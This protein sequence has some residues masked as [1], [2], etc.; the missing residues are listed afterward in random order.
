MSSPLF[1]EVQAKHRQEQLLAEATRERLARKARGGENRLHRVVGRLWRVLTA[2]G[3][4]PTA[5]VAPRDGAPRPRPTR[6][7]ASRGSGRAAA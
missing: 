1:V 2:P 3:A 6:G 4:R 7:G 5:P